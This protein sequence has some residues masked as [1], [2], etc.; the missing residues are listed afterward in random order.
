M[1]DVSEP[2]TLT[3]LGER[4]GVREG[5][6]LVGARLKG[7]CALLHTRLKSRVPEGGSCRV[8]SSVPDTR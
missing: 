7:G 1:K 2:L 6:D 3:L 4:E 8:S 5:A